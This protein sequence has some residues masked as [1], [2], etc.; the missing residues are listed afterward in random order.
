MQSVVNVYMQPYELHLNI[1]AL[2]H[3]KRTLDP[4]SFEYEECDKLL[5]H[6]LYTYDNEVITH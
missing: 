3:Y 2:T 4:N 1:Q 6:Y 5:K